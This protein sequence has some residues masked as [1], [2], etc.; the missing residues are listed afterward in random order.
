[1]VK[2]E[3]TPAIRI[4]LGDEIKLIDLNTAVALHKQLGVTIA[5]LQI[6]DSRAG[7]G[8]P[9]TSDGSNPQNSKAGLKTSEET[10]V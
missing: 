2:A 1:M 6:R 5:N 3:F 8:K 10:V 4:T 9:D 7:V